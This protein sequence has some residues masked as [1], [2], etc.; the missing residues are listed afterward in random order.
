MARIAA[1]GRT[2][3]APLTVALL[4][5]AL[6]VPAFWWGAP[7]ATAA[8]RT[9]AWGT[10]EL[11][12]LGPLAQ[13]HDIIAPKAEMNPN[14][15]YPMLHTF[16]LLGAF[17]PYVGFLAASGGLTSPT[18]AYPHGFADP[19][20][21]LRN[22]SLISHFLSVLLAVGIVICAFGLAR[23][24]WDEA[25]ATVAALS[26]MLVYPMFYYARTSNVDVPVLFFIAAGLWVFAVI[27]RR[28]LTLRRAVILG[29]MAGCAVAIKEQ[30]FASFAFVPIVLPLLRD[31]ATGERLWRSRVFWK[32]AP[33][34]AL[35]AFA[36]YAVLSG[37]VVDSD[38]W[39]AHIRFNAERMELARSGG[40]A[41]TRYY[42]FSWQGHVELASKIVV[43]LRDALSLPGLALGIAGLMV[44]VKRSRSG[45][46]LAYS[47]LVYLLI[48]F[49]SARVV[50][51]RYVMPVAFIL[52]LYAGFAVV[53]AWRA[54]RVVKWGTAAIAGAAAVTLIAWAADLTYAMLNDSRHAAGAWLA[55]RA[56]PGDALEYF[57]PSNKNPPMPVSLSSRQAIPAPSGIHAA[58]TG[59]AAIQAVNTGWQERQP[60]FVALIPDY[61]SHGDAPYSASCPPAIYRALE[62]GSLGYSR[63]AIFRT[64]ALIAW[65]RRPPLDHPVVNPPIRL[66]ER[67][68]GPTS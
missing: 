31:A 8:D 65:S 33:A 52:A 57:G 62:D 36:M 2:G 51:L 39:L 67:V 66:Y 47:A 44:A 28:G 54:R 38:R 55:A 30:G 3:R 7:H 15:G 37:M 13:A 1:L 16:M 61:T 22:I 45:A 35:S 18:V 68:S 48:L 10:D 64:P 12:P 23:E 63:A 6:Y 19:V 26:A 41:F 20:T 43:L 24:L 25:T 11:A 50:Q 9:Y 49:F 59:Q 53:S 17:A 5:F 34:G 60:R 56:R 40:V 4:A 14:L 29:A 32:A 42:P 21:A 46:L 58:D 27:A